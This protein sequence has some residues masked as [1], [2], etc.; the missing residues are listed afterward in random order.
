MP[1]KTTL[2]TAASSFPA[3]IRSTAGLFIFIAFA[4][5]AQSLPQAE[6]QFTR[7]NYESVIQS[8]Q[9]RTAIDN[10]LEWRLLMVR[11]LQALGRYDEAYTNALET[12]DYYPANLRALLLAR[13]TA[14][15]KND[16]GAVNRRLLELRMVI[17]RRG[18]ASTSP[19][20]LVALGQALLLLGVEPRIVLENCFHR[21]QSLASPPREAYLAPGQLA[22]DKH[23]FALAA[24]TFREGL[25]KFP[26][27]PDFHWG[28]AA[29][30]EPGNREEMLKSIQT[31]LDKNP[32]HVPSLLLLADH[33]IDAEQY[34]EAEKQ[35]ALA[36]K[37][38][39]NRPEALAYR[40][41]LA[42]LRNDPTQEEQFRAA[43]LK[44]WKTN[45]EVDHLIGLKLSRKYRFEEG[46]A[47]QRRA[48]AFDSGYLPA[49]RQ[50]AE[51]LLRLGQNDEGWKLAEAVHKE[52][53]Y[54]VN[55]YNLATLHDRMS[56]FQALTNAHFVVRM[57]PLEAQLYGE[58][59]L[60]LL[61]RARDTLSKKYG[62]ELTR[63]TT[64]EIFPEQKDFSVRTFGMP[65]NPGY[66][67]VCFG[68]V[69][70]AN[71]P[72]S[73]APNPANW[74]D[75]LWH[76]FT[77]VITLTA[78]KN[79]M[80]RWLSEGISVYEEWQA[81]PAWGE[82]MNLGYRTMILDGELTP[83]SKL[84]SAFLTPKTPQHLQFAYLESALVVEF[85]VDKFGL[86]ALKKI[87]AD[88]RDGE[89]INKSIEARTTSMAEVEKQFASFAKEK[90]QKLA[91][92]VDLE[93]PPSGEA[94]FSNTRMR[95]AAGP[96]NRAGQ[97]DNSQ[98][99]VTPE[100]DVWEKIHADNYYVRMR[101]AQELIEAKKW[102]EAKPVV[103][104]LADQY[105]GESGAE[106]PLW[107]LAM[108][109]R[110]L[111]E[112]N[113]EL[114]T[115]R[116]FAERESDFVDLYTRLIELCQV[117]GNWN[118]VTNYAERLLAVNPL[119]SL[120]YRA[121]ADAAMKLADAP[122]A[123]FALRGLLLL[124]PADPADVHYQLARLLHAGGKEP[125]QARREVLEALEEAPRFRDAQRLLL[126]I[127]A[128]TPQPPGGP[129]T[130]KPPVAE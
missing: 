22:L 105:A 120:P 26:D 129:A 42:H 60:A 7:G 52:D 77:H 124:D 91:P 108:V 53:E 70:T 130:S 39:P 49:Q 29:A 122:Q 115:L 9:R 101:K 109:H 43:A 41:V 36:L 107:L 116:K 90:A 102:A 75:V 31:A 104:S 92:G 3:V 51:D 28:L 44:Y 11:S 19:D 40:A 117:K 34:D 71:S 85:I 127:S 80:P 72:A 86:D 24:E 81:N 61:D 38:N 94:R 84:S 67:G 46:A 79:R 82:R 45:P 99:V 68:S 63:Q 96:R 78:T 123:I 16:I 100:V 95:P 2:V 93:K 17:E 13:D 103:Q 18:A 106:N 47:E 58:R 27:D 50:L 35:L 5:V 89:E 55:A 64:V 98:T 57:A 118:A 6:E 1:G 114:A 54:D 74:E 97:E 121:L 59:V 14:F 65:G 23:D 73:Q 111:N 112:T 128:N 37:V 32:R 66:L 87:L 113:A 126:E 62:I 76:E 69:I 125:D 25:K 83:L 33:L 110:N 8:A 20:D 10:S 12:V 15:F 21:A 48:L 119:L 88:L 56:K 30:Y 4:A